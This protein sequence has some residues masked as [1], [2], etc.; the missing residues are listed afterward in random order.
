MAVAAQEI[1]LPQTADRWIGGLLGAATA[2]A[3]CTVL[4]IVG[5]LLYSSMPLL[6]SGEFIE[7]VTRHWRPYHMP[8][9]YGI[10]PMILGSL[11][12]AL[13]ALVLALPLGVGLCSF[14]HG[15]APRRLSR[16]VLIAVH[17]MTSI[18]TVIYGFVSV[19]LLVPLLR[20]GLGE[21]SG[22]S[23]LAAALTLAMLIV[24]TIT[25]L[26]NVHLQQIDPRIRIA[27]LSLGMTPAQT[28][29]RVLLPASRQAL[30]AATILGLSRALGD[31]LVALMVAGNAA[32]IP[33]S[34][35]DSIRTLTAHIAL[36]LATDTYS[37]EYRSLAAAGL[38]LFTL[39][40]VLSLLIRQ[41]GRHSRGGS[42]RAPA[43]R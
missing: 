34:L 22:F 20:R 18:P 14:L 21:G 6:L 36:V 23:L 43:I 41:L 24:P 11:S 40:A 26:L 31:T 28:V 17:L 10:G 39:T 15:L 3:A 4:L 27:C 37:P 1:S 2:T 29:R 42:H 38:M 19:S 25:L 33:S 12:L 16:P 30:L 5:F 7:T 32:Q 35:L 13:L 9:E 8:P